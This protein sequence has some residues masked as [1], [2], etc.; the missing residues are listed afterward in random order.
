MFNS[1]YNE[2]IPSTFHALNIRSLDFREKWNWIFKLF[3]QILIYKIELFARFWST[4]AKRADG[5]KMWC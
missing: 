4:V 1:I 3:D 5:F 2:L